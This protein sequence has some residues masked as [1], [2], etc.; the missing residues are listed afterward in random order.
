VAESVFA[1]AA[2]AWNLPWDADWVTSVAFIG[3]SRR[4]AAGNNLGQIMLW[5]LPEKPGGEAP[6][7]IRRLD[8]HTNVVSKLLSTADGKW[9]VSSSYDHTIR[10]WDTAAA[11]ERNED[12]VLNARAIADAEA[13]KRN[14]AKVPPPVPAKIAVQP[15]A[16]TLNSHKEWVAGLSFSKDEKRLLSGDDAG[17]AILWDF[18]A[19]KEIRR[20]ALKG[21][22]YALALSPDGTRA[23]ISERRPLVFD[24][25]RLTAVRLWDAEKGEPVK[26]LSADYKDMYIGSAAFSPDGK[27]LVVGRGGEAAGLN[28]KLWLLNAADGKKV[29]ELTPAHQDGVTDIVFH[30]GGKHF[31]SA[32]RDTV[33]RLWDAADGKMVKEFGKGRGGQFK[34]WVCAIAFSADGDWL[35]AADMAGAVQ[36]WHLGG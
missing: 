29:K 27:L 32:G 10:L 4:L 6:K 5:E 23:L 33:V 26:D 20:S 34:D 1:K 15:S 8:G 36:V 17:V 14:G 25:G 3:S 9:L 21:W 19:R 16:Q 18:P 30:P 12:L 2:L 11:T 7:P 28:G 31:A 22:A 13:R 24:T 35:A